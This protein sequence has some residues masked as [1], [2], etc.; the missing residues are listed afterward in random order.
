M[1]LLVGNLNTASAFELLPISITSV[2]ID[3]SKQYEAGKTVSGNFVVQSAAEAGTAYDLKY[4]VAI[5]EGGKAGE[6]TIVYGRSSLSNIRIDSG[7][8]RFAFNFAIPSSLPKGKNLSIHVQLFQTDGT[9]LNWAYA[10]INIDQA[11]IKGDWVEI[12]NALVTVKGERFGTGDGPTIYEAGDGVLTFDAIKT[13]Q[14]SE[15]FYF[16][17]AISDFSS[18]GE[19]VKTDRMPITFSGNKSSVTLELPFLSPGVYM[20]AGAIYEESGQK[21]SRDFSFRYIID[22]DVYK[23]RGFTL[24]NLLSGQISISGKPV[25]QAR[26]NQYLQDAANR[27]SALTET[28]LDVSVI[29]RNE[30]GEEV[31]RGKSEV[32]VRGNDTDL[33]VALKPTETPINSEGFLMAM[34]SLSRDGKVID[35]Y[36]Q[37]ISLPLSID[38]TETNKSTFDIQ[39][40]A[41]R[42]A[43]VLLISLCLA[44]LVYLVLKYA[45]NIGKAA[46]ISLVLFILLLVASV[47]WLPSVY[48]K[49]TK[50]SK[51]MQV[52]S[53]NW[54]LLGVDGVLDP[55]I[56]YFLLQSDGANVPIN[57]DYGY[58]LKPGQKFN[59]SVGVF[60]WRC[61]NRFHAFL[62][63]VFTNNQKSKGEKGGTAPG[64]AGAKYYAPENHPLADYQTNSSYGTFTAPTEPGFYSL[65]YEIENMQYSDTPWSQMGLGPE[66]VANEY[67]RKEV[68]KDFETNKVIYNRKDYNT[69]WILAGKTTA[70]A[71]Y[72]VLC[73][74]GSLP[75]N[76]CDTADNGLSSTTSSTASKNNQTCR[77]GYT[78]NANAGRCVSTLCLGTVET[79]AINP[80]TGEC[81]CLN[82]KIN[83]PT[84]TEAANPSDCTIANSGGRI[85]LHG[86][87]IKMYEKNLVPNND[88][89]AAHMAELTCYNGKL[90]KPPFE[91]PEWNG[92]DATVQG[93]TNADAQ[94]KYTTCRVNPSYNE[95]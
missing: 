67:K 1:G 53:M 34:V 65:T 61:L 52:T 85:V 26:L 87:K 56:T 6:P 77:S 39:D 38:N 18:T 68:V 55:T 8:N 28:L 54:K 83:P 64:Q 66:W 86:E 92:P 70:I 16:Q 20:G 63:E 3:Q 11:S 2:N 46:I 94:Y 24:N 35:S 44:L 48:A 71:N 33:S 78:Y 12:Q 7:D 58:K 91:I 69:Y 42:Y 36:E 62:T 59:V 29:V 49:T 22:G 41:L 17:Y 10:P 88:T 79:T 4:N 13:S 89:C 40:I 95:I 90:Y 30:S 43:V 25:D 9:P 84:C 60:S 27:E 23:I 72:V 50:V 74:N 76:G 14:K 93:E 21:V 73:P 37:K 45:L 32:A 47:L 19:Y 81:Y 15:G 31:A 82:G 51:Y 57:S 80:T 5:I 75:I